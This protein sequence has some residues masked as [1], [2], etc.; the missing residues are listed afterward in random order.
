M[1]KI[2]LTGDIQI[3]KSTV[4]LKTLDLLNIRYAGFRTYFG[5][6]RSDPDKF[7]YMNEASLARC[8][9]D[10]NAVV[11]FEN[12]KRPVP[13]TNRFDLLGSKY[14][15]DAE[16]NSQLIIMDECG[17]FESDA[18]SFKSKI[19]RILDEEI[20]VLG[21]IK[22]SA[23][24]WVERIRKHPSVELITVDTNNRDILPMELYEKLRKCLK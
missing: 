12:G 4:I 16:K 10:N 22:L 8:F 1:K 3:G 9:D 18:T 24:G 15:S 23:S 11:I 21:V 17:N 5:P 6:D 20:P 14:L 2:F 13:L 19:F 7:L